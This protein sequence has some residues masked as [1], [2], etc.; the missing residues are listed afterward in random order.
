MSAL[1]VTVTAFG[2]ELAAVELP[3]EKNTNAISPADV[4]V[5]DAAMLSKL[6]FVLRLNIK[7]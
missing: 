7:Q 3:Y 2:S 5:V 6:P 4:G 1:W